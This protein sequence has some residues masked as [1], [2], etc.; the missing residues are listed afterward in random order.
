MSQPAVSSQLRMLEEEYNLR[1]YDRSNQGMKLT[2][3]GRDFIEEIRPVLARLDTLEREFKKDTKPNRFSVLAVGGSNTLS[4]AV[5]PEIL[6]AFRARHPD[7][8]L[9]MA[10]KPSTTI[11]ADVLSGEVEVALVTNPTYFPHCVYEPYK[12]YEG[13]AFVPPD[14]A[15]PDREMSLGELTGYPLVVKRDSVIIQ[16][17]RR[18]GYQPSIA[19]QCDAA[20]AV[21]KAAAEKGLGVGL[22]FAGRV[23]PEVESGRLR[24]LDVPELRDIRIKSFIVYDNRRPLS[25]SALDFLRT[26]HDSKP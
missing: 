16:E 13:A 7:V 14:S 20:D 26:L 2:Q 1:F 15:I 10:T 17:I 22:L 24:M 5:F 21:I 11:E 25:N 3:A 9:V 8:E 6:A 18:R 4:V 19:V 23:E 12:D